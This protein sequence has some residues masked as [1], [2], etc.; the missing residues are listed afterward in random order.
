MK[1]LQKKRV[2]KNK[3]IVNVLIIV[4]LLL[5]YLTGGKYVGYY[6]YLDSYYSGGIYN[7]ADIYESYSSWIDFFL[8]LIIFLG[9]GQAVLG[10]H[11][12]AQGGK[13]VFVG[14][15]IFLAFALLLWE[16]QTGFSLVK[17]LGPYA[18]TVFLLL[19]GT[20]I[21]KWIHNASSSALIAGSITYFLIVIALMAT[22]TYY[23]FYDIS[24]QFPIFGLFFPLNGELPVLGVIIA[25]VLLIIGMFRG[26]T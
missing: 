7:I 1:K 4:T 2:L 13:A 11:F 16:Q 8:F 19:L 3:G 14:L 12:K 25:V 21:Y 5:F 22:P 18:F 24:Y 15:G 6:P 23:G 10:E 26:R 20:L 17:N 9:L